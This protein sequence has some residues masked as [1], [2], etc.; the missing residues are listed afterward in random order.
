MGGPRRDPRARPPGGPDQ[1]PARGGARGRTPDGVGGSSDSGT[2]PTLLSGK[3]PLDRMLIR[4]LGATSP[5]LARDRRAG[6]QRATPPLR[7]ALSS[8]FLAARSPAP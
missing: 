4:P 8:A 5:T 7:A 6:C 3:L 1:P 2:P